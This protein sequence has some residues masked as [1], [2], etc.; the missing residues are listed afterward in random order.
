MS[1]CL[2]TAVFWCLIGALGKL[3]TWP[4]CYGLAMLL[5]LPA[6]PGALLEYLLVVVAHPQ[7]GKQ[8]RPS[9]SQQQ[10]RK[11]RR[12]KTDSSCYSNYKTALVSVQRG[13][14]SSCRPCGYMH[15]G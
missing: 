14:L 5:L 13:P 6:S 2:P 7:S 1:G 4:C 11:S 15:V 3:S 9:W 10:D 8:Q 12:D